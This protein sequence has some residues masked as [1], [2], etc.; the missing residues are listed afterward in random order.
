MSTIRWRGNSC[1]AIVR[2]KQDGVLVL[3]EHRSFTGE[4]RVRVE[5]LARDWAKRLEESIESDGVPHRKLQATTLGALLRMHRKALGDDISG[6]KAGE[7][8]RLASEFDDVRL[9]RITPKAFADFATRRRDGGASP[10]TVLHNLSTVR[11]VLGIAKVMYGIDV[12]ADVVKE[13]IAA[14]TKLKV[15]AKGKPRTRRPTGDELTRLDEYFGR[16]ESDPSQIIPMRHAMWLAIFLPRR[17]GEL[18]A[19]LW[20]DLEANVVTLRDTKHPTELR[21]ETVPV[22]PA[23]QEIIEQL[24]ARCDGEPRIL[25]FKC[26]SI[27]TAWRRACNRISIYDLH[28]HDLRREGV[29]RL[30][31]AGYTIPEVSKI[32]GHLD[33]NMLQIYTELRPQDILEK[34]S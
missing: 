2:K 30:F 21:D 11:S 4:D 25:P 22:L 10:S 14:L 9:A 7:L 8:E 13:A 20:S 27:G 5:R 26:E 16:Q 32:S 29:S 3:S 6:T 23:A 12:S 17:V 33:W 31:K 24:R 15:I 19:M 1:T 28:F 34:F 18:T